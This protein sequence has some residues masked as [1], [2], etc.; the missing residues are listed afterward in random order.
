MHQPADRVAGREMSVAIAKLGGRSLTVVVE[1]TDDP[2]TWMIIT[3]WESTERER[4]L[5]GS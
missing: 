1:A 4:K 2:T 5:R 3:A